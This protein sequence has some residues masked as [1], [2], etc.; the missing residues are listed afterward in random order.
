MI[1]NFIEYMWYLLTT[2]L[3][4]LKRS[5]NK[6][7]IL[8]KVYGRRFDE[9]KEDILRARDEGMVATCCHEM[10]PVHG[11]DRRLTRYDGEH[12]ENYR[13]RIAM[14]EEVCKLGGTNEGVLLAVKTL[15]Y[16]APEHV[17][18]NDK[19]GFV[20][21]TLD[22]S[23]LLDGSRILESDTIE[24]RWAEF[25]IVIGMDA[26]EEH[27]I[28]FDIL[29]KTVR[30]WKEVGAKDNYFFRYTLSIREINSMSFL[31]VLYKKYLYYFDYLKLDGMWELD[32]SHVLDAERNPYTTRIG[33]R[34]ESGYEL[35]EAG[36][37]AVAYCYACRVV[38][39][40]VLKAAYSFRAQYFEYLKTDGTWQTDGS[41]VLD[42]EVS[43]REMKW[44]TIFRHQHEEEL[45]LKQAYQLPPC[46]EEHSIRIA[47]EQYRMVIDYFSYLKLN[48]LWMLNG[49][50][51]MD[52]QRT[53][54]TTKQGYR[55]GVEHTRE[56][57]V[58][59]H[60]QHNLIFLDGTWSLDGSKIIDAWQKTE[61]L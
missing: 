21:F 24:N 25:Y 31:S 35:H 7:Y 43:P 37:L 61:V 52:A 9:V 14:Y 54:Y 6:W 30:K 26:D 20:H 13:S 46:E 34:Y 57:R 33:Y 1:E 15:G 17:R 50:R 55:L 29:R 44:G 59:W 53:E 16:T 38:E 3:K 45:L 22:G 49:S 42:A 18:A 4:K 5:L 47:L 39:E 27:P 28:S 40:A 58:I 2:P 32:G 36:L 56:Y 51:L 19:T 12:P 41:H 48:G 11:A 10:L 23:W 8:C 60:E